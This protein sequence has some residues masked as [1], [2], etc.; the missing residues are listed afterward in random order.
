MRW[1]HTRLW[2]R[3]HLMKC[4][5]Q[6]SA[7]SL[8]GKAPFS[9][10]ARMNGTERGAGAINRNKRG[11]LNNEPLLVLGLVLLTLYFA[12]DLLIPFAMALTLNFLLAPAV[13]QLERLRLPRLPAVIL[14][15]LLVSAFMAVIGW[16]VVRQL[17]DVASDL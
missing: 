15:V 9:G 17:L 8:I 13:I 12:R 5:T 2:L 16:V 10:N 4:C 3:L 6:G 7:Q 11:W 1:F 14:V